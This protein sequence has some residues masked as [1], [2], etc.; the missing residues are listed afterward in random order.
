MALMSNEVR[1]VLRASGIMYLDVSDVQSL[2]QQL[3]F[4]NSIKATCSSWTAMT[5]LW[6]VTTDVELRLF[7]LEA[8][9]EEMLTAIGF[10]ISNIPRESPRKPPHES[11]AITIQINGKA[12]AL[13]ACPVSWYVRDVIIALRCQYPY[14]TSIISIYEP[15]SWEVRLV[16]GDQPLQMNACLNS[17]QHTNWIL[18]HRRTKTEQIGT[19]VVLRGFPFA[20]SES[21]V[22]SFIFDNEASGHVLGLSLVMSKKSKKNIALGRNFSGWVNVVLDGHTSVDDFKNRVHHARSG[23]RYI[24]VLQR[25]SYSHNVKYYRDTALS[26]L[27][28]AIETFNLS[29]SRLSES[30]D[31]IPGTCGEVSA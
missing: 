25:T 13:C 23:E 16:L 24:E 30:S 1:V 27:S 22:W 6:V 11:L 2:L 3:Q 29:P 20:F 18:V 26:L 17:V 14:I 4:S 19:E 8:D 31:D 9:V 12:Y 15:E 21:D 10:R 28:N 5:T 7:V